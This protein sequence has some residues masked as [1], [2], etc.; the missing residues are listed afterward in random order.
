[1]RVVCV[2]LLFKQKKL[3]LIQNV[4]FISI[5]LV[6]NFEIKLIIYKK[7]NLNKEELNSHKVYCQINLITCFVPYG[8]N[9]KVI[10]K[11]KHFFVFIVA[12]LQY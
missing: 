5:L 4:C 8:Q 10:I 11:R 3:K 7:I 9:L 12:Y 6:F 2:L 1:M